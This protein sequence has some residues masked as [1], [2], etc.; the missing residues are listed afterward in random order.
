MRNIRIFAAALCLLAAPVFAQSTTQGAIAGTVEDTT[1]ALVPNATITI[2]NEGTDAE[3]HLSAD[4]SGYF[5]APLVEPGSYT[6][7]I[8][9]SNFGTYVADHVQVQVGQLTTLAP[10]LAAG[11]AK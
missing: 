1:D 9:A 10:K 2:H 8:S 5:K 4:A 11:S 7:T 6:V 3:V